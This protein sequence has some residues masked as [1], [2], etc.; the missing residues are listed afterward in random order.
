MLIGA[1]PEQPVTPPPQPQTELR[2]PQTIRT[3][4]SYA[5]QLR[6][7]QITSDMAMSKVLKALE[8]EIPIIPSRDA[9]S[10]P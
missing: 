2:T 5:R 1:E 10:T 7:G 8:L 3:L 9:S 4:R 6:C